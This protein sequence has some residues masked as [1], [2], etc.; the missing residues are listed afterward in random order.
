MSE[1]RRK[2][3]LFQG[4]QLTL[5]EIAKITGINWKTLKKRARRGIPFDQPLRSARAFPSAHK[6]GLLRLTGDRDRDLKAIIAARHRDVIR[7]HQ[8]A[9]E[10]GRCEQCV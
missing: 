4:Q 9:V 2:R 6:K 1:A 7:R 5:I 8:Q 10:A 3:H